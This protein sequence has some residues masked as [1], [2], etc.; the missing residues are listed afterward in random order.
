MTIRE[1][2][3]HIIF[4]LLISSSSSLL[5]FLYLLQN[6]KNILPSIIPIL[7]TIIQLVVTEK[8]NSAK[9][10]YPTKISGYLVL[11]FLFFSIFLFVLFFI[12]NNFFYVK[13][14]AFLIM[15]MVGLY[16]SWYLY[17]IHKKNQHLANE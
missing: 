2:R 4:W 3:I 9:Y 15:S 6:E 11:N 16:S 13:L 17:K 14:G 5:I 7:G 12:D 8:L 1:N 10:Y